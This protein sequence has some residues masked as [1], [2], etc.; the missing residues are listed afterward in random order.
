M[1]ETYRLQKEIIYDNLENPYV[2]M[3][4]Y[5]GREEKSYDELFTKMNKLLNLFVTDIKNKENDAL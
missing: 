3:I 4:S 1:R 5:I 2:F